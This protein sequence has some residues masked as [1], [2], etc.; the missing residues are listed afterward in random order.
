M[1]AVQELKDEVQGSLDILY[2]GPIKIGT[3]PQTLTVDVDTGSAD[4]WVPVKCAQCE[5]RLFES[6]SSS[7]YHNS[8]ARFKVAYG[9]GQV[10]GTLASDVVAIGELTISSQY[11]GAISQESDDFNDSPND[12]LIGM[13]FGTIA[14]SK[15]P[16]FFENLIEQKKVAAPLFSIHLT[17][18]QA[19]GSEARLDSR[20]FTTFRVCFGC[21]DATKATGPVSW[22]PVKSQTYWS[23]AMDAISVGPAHNQMLQTDIVAAIDTGTTLI[24]LPDSVA[25]QFYAMIPGARNAPQY[26]SAFYTYPC[27]SEIPISFSFGGQFYGINMFDF[28][29]GQTDTNSPDCVGGILGLGNGFPANLGIIGAP[30]PPPWYSTYDYSHGA[31]VGFSPS[32]NN[33]PPKPS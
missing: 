16:T 17:R 8:G 6:R 20:P 4:L 1:T 14:Q 27:E 7:T 29:L 30:F 24:Y 13:A 26:G 21:Y 15:K 2:Y 19:G 18:N 22:I 12:G 31:R 5:N 11:F 3:P 9:Q 23:V 25:A 33:G 28:N 10:S 32:I